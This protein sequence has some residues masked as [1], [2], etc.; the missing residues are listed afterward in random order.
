MSSVHKVS[1]AVQTQAWKGVVI[2]QTA[3]QDATQMVA[4]IEM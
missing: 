4:V 3:T 1:S 2:R